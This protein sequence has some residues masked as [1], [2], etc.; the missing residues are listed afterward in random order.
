MEALKFNLKDSPHDLLASSTTRY[1]ANPPSTGRRRPS[2]ARSFLRRPHDSLTGLD[3]PSYSRKGSFGTDKTLKVFDFK[4][5][6]PGPGAYEIR[7]ST[8]N[9]PRQSW[10]RLR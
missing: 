6:S 9:F 5:A 10:R 1:I 7:Y 8:Y 3:S 2:T 4:Y